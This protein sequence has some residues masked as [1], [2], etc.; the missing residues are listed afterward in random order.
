MMETVLLKKYSNRR[1]YNT[2]KSEYVTLEQVARLIKEG[3]T[4][5]VID[6]KSKADVTG[7]VLNQIILE[8]SRYH[9]MLPVSL[10][11]LIIRYGDNLLT[12]FFEHYLEETLEIYIQSKK[13]F[14]DH[15]RQWI[16]MGGSQNPFT[17]MFELFGLKHD[18][19]DPPSGDGG[20]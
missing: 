14:D 17:G 18:K 12:E 16:K 5:K 11:H 4:V 8:E 1:L 3:R 19:K 10:L 2:E 7:F 9:A 13:S 20:K 15:F 6:A